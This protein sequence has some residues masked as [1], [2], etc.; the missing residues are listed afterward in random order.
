MLKRTRWQR[1]AG[2]VGPR[3]S[4]RPPRAGDDSAVAGERALDE[5]RAAAA[6][7]LRAPARRVGQT[8][9]PLGQ[10]RLDGEGR[11]LEVVRA[12]SAAVRPARPRPGRPPRVE[13]PNGGVSSV[14]VRS[15]NGSGSTTSPMPRTRARPPRGRTARRRRPTRPR[16]GRRRRPSAGRPPRRPSRRRGPR[17]PGCACPAARGPSAPTARSARRTRLSSPAA[18]GRPEP[19]STT[20]RPSP[21]GEGQLVGEVERHHLGV[22][23]VVAVVPDAGDP[24]RQRQLR[25]RDHLRR[26]SETTASGAAGPSR[27]RRAPRP[28]RLGGDAGRLEGAV[29]STSPASERRSILRRW[30]NPARTSANSRSGSAPT[31]GRGRRRRC[32]PAPTPPAAAGRNTSGPTRP[33]TAAVGPVRDLHRRDAVGRSPGPAASR[34]PDLPLHHHQHPVDGGHAV[35]QVEHERRRD[36]VRAGWRP[37]STPARAGEQRRASR[38]PSRRPPRPAPADAPATDLAQDAAG[39]GGRPRPPITGRPVSASAR[40]S[41]PSP[42]PTS[43]T[44]SPGPTPASRAMRRT[45]LGSTTKFCPSARLGVSPCRRAAPAA[46]PAG[47]GHAAPGYQV[48]R[49]EIT[50]AAERRRGRKPVGDE[51]DDVARPNGPPVVDRAGDLPAVGWR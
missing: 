38:A 11:G 25:R 7:Q 49:T 31:A 14:K 44:W 15:T 18:T 27:R 42:A 22:D 41:E 34:S 12:G 51:V 30:P 10:P 13:Q 33:T 26:P 48:M 37:A 46:S 4:G 20:S 16:R 24:Q 40:V 28:G 35:E 9:A 19:A 32:A 29:G 43:T 1:R 50:P 3:R 6:G 23:E 36:V 47:E 5:P 21:V 39:R 17:R 45:V 2:Q 8:V